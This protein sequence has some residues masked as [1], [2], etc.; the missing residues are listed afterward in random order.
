MAVFLC[1]ECVS[2]VDKGYSLKHKTFKMYDSEDFACEEYIKNKLELANRTAIDGL[3]LLSFLFEAVELSQRKFFSLAKC[4][5]RVILANLKEYCDVLSKFNVISYTCQNPFYHEYEEMSHHLPDE[6]IV[7]LRDF[8]T[9]ATI[10]EDYEVSPLISLYYNDIIRSYRELAHRCIT[11]TYGFDR[12]SKYDGFN[13]P[14][15]SKENMVALSDKLSVYAQKNNVN[16]IKD[17]LFL[18]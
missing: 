4:S 15:E 5:F 13:L 2:E 6:W 14:D 16:F 11:T 12:S 8:I 17:N 7:K 1:G 9:S 10:A 3:K 18:I